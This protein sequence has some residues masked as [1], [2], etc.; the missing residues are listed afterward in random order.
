[1]QCKPVTALPTG[2]KWTFEIKFDAERVTIE[3]GDFFERVPS[4]GD[5]YLLSHIIHDW[6]EGDP[7]YCGAKPQVL[8]E[9]TLRYFADKP[10]F[11]LGQMSWYQRARTSRGRGGWNAPQRRVSRAYEALVTGQLGKAGEIVPR[12]IRERELAKALHA[13][14]MKRQSKTCCAECGIRATPTAISIYTASPSG[15]P[16]TDINAGFGHEDKDEG[17]QLLLEDLDADWLRAHRL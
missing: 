6:R 16:P 13:G 15:S 17:S 12:H 9:E 8:T 3:G 10:G 1:M 11:S 2:E 4:C 7:A 14:P 5:A